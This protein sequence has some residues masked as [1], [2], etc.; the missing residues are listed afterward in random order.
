M[1]VG[2]ADERLVVG[3]AAHLGAD[4]TVDGQRPRLPLQQVDDGPHLNT[5]GVEGGSAWR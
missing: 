2:V 5:I 4:V 3:Q 1:R